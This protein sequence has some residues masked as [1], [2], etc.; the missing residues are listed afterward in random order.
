MFENI[1]NDIIEND[2]NIK[3][4]LEKAINSIDNE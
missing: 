3:A 1:A 2:I 4:M